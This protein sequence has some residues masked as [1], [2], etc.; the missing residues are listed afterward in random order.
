MV[1]QNNREFWVTKENKFVRKIT[2]DQITVTLMSASRAQEQ[3]THSLLTL[4]ENVSES[5]A[6][7]KSLDFRKLE[8]NLIFFKY[9]SV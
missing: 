9:F 1:D 2:Q 3:N 4:L 7:T 5:V 8:K 6:W